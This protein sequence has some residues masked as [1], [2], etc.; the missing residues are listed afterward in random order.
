MEHRGQS[1]DA[2]EAKPGRHKGELTVRAVGKEYPVHVEV[3]VLPLRLPDKL[4]FVVDLNCYSSVREGKPGTPEWWL[5]VDDCVWHVR[6]LNTLKF[7]L[8]V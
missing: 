7:D 8:S 6:Q 4:N 2:D 1:G 3:E 5:C